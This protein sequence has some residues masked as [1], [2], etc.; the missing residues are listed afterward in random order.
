VTVTGEGT[1]VSVGFGSSPSL[2]PALDA[3]VRTLLIPP[4]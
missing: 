2:L 1:T 4:A 3:I